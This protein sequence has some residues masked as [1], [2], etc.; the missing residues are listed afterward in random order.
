MSE[1]RILHLE[2]D[3]LDAELV[4]STLTDAGISCEIRRVDTEGGFVDAL[5]Q[6]KFDLIISDFSMPGFNGKGAL[7][8]ARQ[9]CPEVPFIFVSGT[10]GEDAAIESLLGCATEYVLKHR[11]SRLIP[12]VQRA[13]REALQRSRSE[14]ALRHSEERYRQVFE[15]SPYPKLVYDLDTKAF[16][17]VNDAAVDEYGYS[18]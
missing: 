5:L 3:P 4:L 12:A 15:R 17:A 7:K 13:R 11:F 2:D 16:L 6:D 10:I 1:L 9:Q 8:L 14:E 18:R